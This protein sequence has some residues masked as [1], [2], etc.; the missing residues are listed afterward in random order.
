MPRMQRRL[1][2]TVT[3]SLILSHA[4]Q[5]CHT[6]LV[7]VPLQGLAFPF[8]TFS[9]LAAP[10]LGVITVQESQNTSSPSQQAGGNW[11]LSKASHLP[12]EMRA[13]PS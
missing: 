11:E 7:P 1:V 5:L 4:Y 9:D 3:P 10:N 2:P 12:W 8:C 13:C 6:L